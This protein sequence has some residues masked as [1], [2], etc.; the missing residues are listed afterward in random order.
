VYLVDRPGLTQGTVALGELGVAL[1]DPD[2]YALDVLGGIWNSFGGRLFDEIRSRAVRCRLTG[3]QADF[4]Q[5]NVDGIGPYTWPPN[6]VKRS[7]CDCQLGPIVSYSFVPW[8]LCMSP[9][10][11]HS[12]SASSVRT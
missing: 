8:N 12:S 1:G 4:L 10:P 6:K 2:A 5:H 7:C 9:P 3:R 11:P